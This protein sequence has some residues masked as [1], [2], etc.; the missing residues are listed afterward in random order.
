MVPCDR[1]RGRGQK[2]KYRKFH[3]NRSIK[4]YCEAG[5]TLKQV[6]QRGCRVT[7]LGNIEKLTVCGLG[8]PDLAD[9]ILNK[10]I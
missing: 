1:E 9:P 6:T 10:G 3:L 8:Q 4:N 5:Q 2:M 7:I